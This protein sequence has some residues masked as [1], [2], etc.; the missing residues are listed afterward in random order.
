VEGSNPRDE[1]Q[2]MGRTRHNK[3]CFFPG[4]SAALKGSTVSVRIDQI[5]AYSLFGVIVE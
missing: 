1:A 3:L 2:A 4:D 5:R